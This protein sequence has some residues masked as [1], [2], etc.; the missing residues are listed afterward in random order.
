M[1]IIQLFLLLT[2]LCFG[3]SA[4]ESKKVT[5]RITYKGNPLCHWDVT[6][7]HGDVALSQG[8]TDHNGFVDFGTVRILSNQV[9]A[10]GIKKTNNGEKTWDV[11]G[12]IVLNDN[13]HADFDFDPLVQEMGMPSMLESAWG[14][15]LNDCGSGSTTSTS[16][17]TNNSSSSNSSSTNQTDNSSSNTTTTSENN[18]VTEDKPEPLVV[19][20]AQGYANQK[21]MYEN[22]LVSI[23]RKIEK[24]KEEQAKCKPDSKDFNEL[25]YD[26]QELKLERELTQI[27]LEKTEKSIANGNAP[28]NKSDRDYYNEKEDAIKAEQDKLKENRKK[29]VSP[30]GATN[31]SDEEEI[32][33]FTIYTP[34]Q[35]AEMGTPGLQKLKIEYQT[36]L[37][38][39]NTIL[40]TRGA[41]LSMERKAQIENEILELERMIKLCE[42][43]ILRRKDNN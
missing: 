16:V 4:Q 32:E 24:K 43:E 21:A 9:D 29:G 30:T 36:K 8:K 23:D 41:S 13:G 38:K 2:L 14:L 33:G 19:D 28:L 11:K 34:E 6:L 15:T 3:L 42:E 17:T 7:K 25:E 27:K 37:A 5:M 12:Y 20:P 10:S 39:R 40:K 31:D 35:I 26:I 22:Q 1:K 18:S